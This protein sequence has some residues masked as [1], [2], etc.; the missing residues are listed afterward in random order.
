MSWPPK[1]NQE[2][3]IEVPIR[4]ASGNLVTTGTLSSILVQDGVAVVGPTPVFV[5]GG[6]GAVTVEL[7]AA[8]NNFDRMALLV[9]S[10]AANSRPA[11][12][13]WFNVTNQMDDLPT[14]AE[15]WRTALTETYAAVGST[16]TPEQF[17][18]MLYSMIAQAK[19]VGSKHRSFKLDGATL[20][21][22]FDLDDPNN[23]TSRVRT[24]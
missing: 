4:D 16:A 2:V 3:S 15:I 13:D 11:Y 20:A 5:A 9:F 10:D 17:M 23:A 8:Q 22:E 21:M 24:A 18:H 7:T 14:F 19:N 6:G 12:R 1:K